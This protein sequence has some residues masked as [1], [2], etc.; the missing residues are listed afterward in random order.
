VPGI[1][2]EAVPLA[3]KVAVLSRPETYGAERPERV[4]TLQTHMAWLFFT[5]RRVR[6]LKKPVRY[7]FLDFGTIA[8]RRAA[9]AAEVRL[10]RRLAADVY[11]GLAPLTLTDDRRL[12]LGPYGAVVDWLVVMRRL[13][14][15]LMLDRMLRAG[16]P[17]RARIDRLGAKLAEFYA[18]APRAPLTPEAYLDRLRAGLLESARVLRQPAYGLDAAAADAALG[19]ALEFVERFRPMLAARV[20][21]GR[22]VD[23]HGDLRPEHVCL[24]PEPVVI[25]CLEFNRALRLVDPLDELAYLALE[26]ELLGDAAVGERLLARYAACSGDHVLEPLSIFHRCARALLRARLMAAHSDE[27]G[28]RPPDHYLHQARAYLD[29]ARRCAGALG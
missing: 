26:C 3:D 7:A 9:C 22:I 21:A 16:G 13:P 17:D 28:D 25:D 8:R 2:L 15:A 10:N 1:D 14:E 18:Q 19:A 29:Q 27:P 4:L 20:A 24:E 11:H 12:R 6:K 5:D 23:G